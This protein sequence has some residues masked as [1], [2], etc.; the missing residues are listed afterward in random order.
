MLWLLLVAI[1]AGFY[2]FK[3][4]VKKKILQGVDVLDLMA[5]INI[6]LFIMVLPLMSF[7]DLHISFVNLF[8][9]F[10]AALVGL[11]ANFLINYDYKKCEVSSIAPLLNLNPLFVIVVSYFLLGEVLSRIQW[12]GVG[13]ILI[14][15]Y[16]VTLKDIKHIL[17]PF[18]QVP[19]KY[20]LYFGFAMLLWSLNPPL[21]KIVLGDTTLL[22]Y[23]FYFFIIHGA[24][25]FII[26]A[27]RRRIVATF[28]VFKGM[29]KIFLLLSVLGFFSQVFFASALAIS[30]A[31]VS[32]IMPIRR[33]SSLVTVAFGGKYFKEHNITLKIVSCSI[34][35]AGLF[36]IGLS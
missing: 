2:G 21:K 7:I 10:I 3:D 33:M 25:W 18:T 34:M 29:W 1:S 11:I 12:L 27:L 32:L 8:Y 14:G 31:M 16:L 6:V 22:T 23:L 4:I 17:H 20:Y 5:V 15:T 26:I 30:V 13:L 35:I 28:D 24:M 36:V 19:F 9:L